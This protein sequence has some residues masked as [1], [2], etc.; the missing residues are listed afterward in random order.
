MDLISF[1]DQSRV[2][3]FQAN[4]QV[5]DDKLSEIHERVMDFVKMWTSH[6]AQLQATGS[7][8]HNRFIVLVVDQT[9]V[10]ASG[11][12]IDKAMHFV[13]SLGH[14]YD[15]DFMDRHYYTYVQ[16]DHLHTV[17]ADELRRLYSESIINDETLIYNNLVDTK[18]AF[19]EEWVTPIGRSWV[20][21]VVLKR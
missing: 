12:S 20:K 5:P 13:Q 15:T 7:I 2:W 18:K 21:R 8:L 14:H 1:P 16:N 11:C 6:Q 3:I 10:G 9:M 19:V 4:Q 17:H